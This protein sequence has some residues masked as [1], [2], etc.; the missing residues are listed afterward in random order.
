MR[1]ILMECRKAISKVS[2]SGGRNSNRY[3]E[4]V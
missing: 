1:S 4:A 3:I 2:S